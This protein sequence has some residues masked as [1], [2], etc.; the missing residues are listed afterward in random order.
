[1]DED[2]P[3]FVFNA[4]SFQKKLFGIARKMDVI[5]GDIEVKHEDER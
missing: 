4:I 1:L 3:K 5:T 2:F